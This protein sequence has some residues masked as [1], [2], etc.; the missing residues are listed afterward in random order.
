LQ[1]GLKDLLFL[2]I[3]REFKGWDFSYIE[4]T[5]RVQEQPLS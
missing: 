4:N 3:N 1:K 5:G 2:E